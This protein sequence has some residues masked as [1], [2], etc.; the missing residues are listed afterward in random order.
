MEVNNPG[1]SL[2]ARPTGTVSGP[3]ADQWESEPSGPTWTET[4]EPAPGPGPV[5]GVRGPVRFFGVAMAIG[6]IV[7]VKTIMIAS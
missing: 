5:A 4:L 7:T 1:K 3:V 6:E 2:S